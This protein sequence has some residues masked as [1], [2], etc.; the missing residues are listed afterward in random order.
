MTQH[1]LSLSAVVPAFN[2]EARLPD[3]LRK[4]TAYLSGTAWDWEV[5][6]VDDGS[7][8]GTR[9]IV[10]EFGRMDP[11][12]I[13]Q[14]EPHRGKGGAVKAAL[15]QARG[16]YRFICD[17]DL[18]MPIDEL[19]RFLPPNL[20]NVDVA[21]GSREG[22]GA[23][24]VDEPHFRHLAGR[25]FNIAVRQLIVPGIQDTQCG[26]KMF[27]AAAVDAIFPYVTVDG[28]AFDIEALYIARL[29]G[30]TI[31]E[32]PIEWHYRPESRVRMLRDG[33]GMFAELL[34]IRA[35]AGRG[36]YRMRLDGR[37]GPAA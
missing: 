21:I 10:E 24:R 4:A 28:W 23:M 36:A 22:T 14:A 33:V 29:R 6:V 12:V 32:V 18:S 1:P 5:R 15:L 3:T 31:R 25:A 35:R 17:A 37:P 34:R 7:T 8:D 9:R 30:L 2:E 19:A 16:S 20:T 13:L 26:F 11:R 27:T